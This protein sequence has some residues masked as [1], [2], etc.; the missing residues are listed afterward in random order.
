MIA[1]RTRRLLTIQP[2]ADGGGSE[3]A[4]LRM[5]AALGAEGWDCHVAVPHRAALAEQY[6]AAGA[7]LHVVPMRRITTQGATL[8]WAAAYLAAWPASVVALTRLARRL[9]VD[10][11]HSNSLHCW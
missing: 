6:A 3:T 11:V 10:L 4:L 1:T 2:A 7:T 5:L 8:A 9:G